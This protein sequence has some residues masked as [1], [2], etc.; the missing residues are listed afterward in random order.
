MKLSW[1]DVLD[2]KDFVGDIVYM[3][4]RAR[5]VGYRYF[6]YNG[7]VYEINKNAQDM[8]PDYT[9]VADISEIF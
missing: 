8:E 7:V 5:T 1:R 4:R 9:K 6:T 3:L 2:C